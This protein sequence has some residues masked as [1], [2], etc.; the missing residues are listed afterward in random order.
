MSGWAQG[1]FFVGAAA[2]R[3]SRARPAALVCAVGGMAAGEG[4]I[5]GRKGGEEDGAGCDVLGGEL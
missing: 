2:G 3:V 5:I 4:G 1:D